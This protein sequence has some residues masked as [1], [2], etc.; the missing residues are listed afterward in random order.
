MHTRRGFTIVELVIVMVIMAILLGLGIVSFNRSQAN[1]RDSER[2]ADAATIARGLETR[3]KEGNP[4]LST[5]AYNVTA[6]SYPGTVEMTHIIGGNVSS[7]GLTTVSGG[8]GPEALPGTATTAFSPPG[9]SGDYSGFTVRC[10][11]TCAVG[12]AAVI[13]AQTTKDIYLYEPIGADN[14][15]CDGSTANPCV[16]FNLYWRDEVT[17]DTSTGASSTLHLI[18]SKHQ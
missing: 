15:V 18:R 12:S 10:L 2:D 8:Y 7:Y 1:A 11:G 14:T 9:L 16:R 13:D 6:G 17:K 3:Y 5:S 4:R